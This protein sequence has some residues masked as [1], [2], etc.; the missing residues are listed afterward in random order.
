MKFKIGAVVKLNSGGPIMTVTV[1]RRNDTSSIV[2]CKW[3]I[4]D[5][6]KEDSFPEK[7][8]KLYVPPTGLVR[9]T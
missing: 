6:L 4:N 5:E 1:T 7:S 2:T 3:F 8:L 9:R